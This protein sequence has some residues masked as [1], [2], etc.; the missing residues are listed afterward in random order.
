MEQVKAA[1]VDKMLD[2]GSVKQEESK[3]KP[4]V[5]RYSKTG[6]L[7]GAGHRPTSGYAGTRMEDI[8]EHD[9]ES[10]QDRQ[11]QAHNQGGAE[12]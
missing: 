12:S 3:V 5:G 10:L 11:S 4:D 9:S 2:H 8:K 6:A 1:V 7:Q